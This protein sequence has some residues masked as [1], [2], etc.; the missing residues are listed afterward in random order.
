M[1]E[2]AIETVYED[3]NS[4]SHF[5]PIRD[6]F[7]IY[8]II[9]KYSMAS[10]LSAVIDNLIFIV[11]SAYLSNIYLM[12][13]A[14]RAVSA[15]FNFTLNK[16]IVFKRQGDMVKQSIKY[17]CLVILSGSISATC[18]S[19]LSRILNIHVVP[20]RLVVELILYFFNFYVQKNFIFV[21]REN[22]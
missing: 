5:N 1:E 15:V 7:K 14:G 16:K 3:N 20:I 4:A 18:V 2:V 19:F 21:K 22:R 9:F 12:T 6:S 17:I 8:A 10:L 13:F 11:L